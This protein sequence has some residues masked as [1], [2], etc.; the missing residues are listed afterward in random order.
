MST[1]STNPS[2]AVFCPAVWPV[3]SIELTA[4][5]AAPFTD[6]PTSI[7]RCSDRLAT[8]M[9]VFRFTAVSA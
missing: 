7:S 8:L 9:R 3:L 2:N 6:A 4:L 5:T 1:E